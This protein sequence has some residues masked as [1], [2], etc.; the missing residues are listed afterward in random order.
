LGRE[1]K[2]ILIIGANGYVGG[3]LS[4]LLAQNGHSITAHC[5]PRIPDNEEWCSKMTKITSGDIRTNEVIEELTDQE[6]D[7]VIHLVSLDHNDSNMDPNIV[8]SINVMPVWNILEA[9]KKKENLNQFIYFSTI[10]VY[11]NIPNQ[12]IDESYF[13][14]PLNPYG[15]THLLVENICNMYNASSDI[16]CINV[17]LSNSY[18]RPFFDNNNCWWLV[19]NDLCRTAFTENKIVLKSSGIALRDF[20]NYLDIFK[21][22]DI[23]INNKIE[24]GNNLFH[25]SSGKTVSIIHIAETVKKVYFKK[26]GKDISI[27]LP[28][29]LKPE[30]NTDISSYTI[31][32]KKLQLLGF[33]QETS[34]E[35]GIN[36]LFDYLENHEK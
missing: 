26:Y 10:H 36:E 32:N 35:A 1:V 3:N 2:E 21:A 4:Y 27:E 33:K 14:N 19:V 7:T 24:K 5:H 12:I 34:I 29:G 23:L 6:F 17:R 18:G 31:S 30:L 9:F 13:P 22:I 15:L 28:Y 20:I 11:G 16:I 8:N 25:L